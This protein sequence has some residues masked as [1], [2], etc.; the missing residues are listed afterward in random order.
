MTRLDEL[1]SDELTAIA[2]SSPVPAD[3]AARAI[4]GG[5]RRRRRIGATLAA[6]MAATG[7]TLMLVGVS[8]SGGLAP[9]AP[10][11]ANA[12]FAYFGD[13]GERQLRWHVLDPVTGQYR[14]PDVSTVTPPTT[15]LHY[16]AVSAP[17]TIPIGDGVSPER[18]IGRYD[19]TTG[20]IR[21]YDIPVL[22]GTAP[23]ISPDGRYIVAAAQSASDRPEDA[24]ARLIVVDL[25]SGEAKLVNLSPADAG[26]AVYAPDGSPY[27]F[28]PGD[29]LTWRPDS[30]HVMVG[31]VTVDLS[32]N[33]TGALPLPRDG[34]GALVLPRA[35]WPFNEHYALVDAAGVTTYTAADQ[36]CFIPVPRT[37]P[38]G[39][40]ESVEPS[41]GFDP[42]AEEFNPSP[43]PSS[44]AYKSY[45]PSAPPRTAWTTFTLSP[46]GQICGYDYGQ[47]IGWRG[48]T[49][50][51][52]VYN[53]S[54]DA[55]DFATGARQTL[56]AVS[57]NTMLDGRQGI[58]VVPLDGLS[59]QARGR[60][61]F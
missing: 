3:L 29:G 34:G 21:W 24:F 47:F 33:R 36:P 58:V 54:I 8:L 28:A 38:P 53:D 19:T 52:L 55:F 35:G 22:L 31:T 7:I 17:W 41:P 9:A 60:V 6:A 49:T 1:I 42:S 2:N 39:M 43:G 32:G 46:V 50:V 37:V 44:P 57:R 14:S 16:A 25:T 10:A 11:R 51:L 45:D 26:A 48:P 5:R 30:R 12:I 61:A 27:G 23:R 4:A 20:A 56:R 59:D 13:A 15:D 18:R 40:W